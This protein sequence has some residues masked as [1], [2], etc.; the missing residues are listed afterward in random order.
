MAEGAPADIVSEELV[1][2][3]FGLDCRVVPDPVAGTPDAMIIPIGSRHR[4]PLVHAE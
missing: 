4:R 3:V 1:A 2:K